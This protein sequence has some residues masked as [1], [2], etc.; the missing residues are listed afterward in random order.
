MIKPAAAWP[1]IEPISQVAELI[2]AADGNIS[3]GTTCEI[4]A[5]NVGPE[6]DLMAPVKAITVH[7]K[8]AIVQ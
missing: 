1:H 6:N 5:E 4:S 8:T 7:I 3:F 2:A